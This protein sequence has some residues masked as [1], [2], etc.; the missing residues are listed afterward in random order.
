MSIDVKIVGILFSFSVFHKFLMKEKGQISVCYNNSKSYSIIIASSTMPNILTFIS[1][2]KKNLYNLFWKLGEVP[3]SLSTLN[4][5]FEFVMLT[6][7]QSQWHPEARWPPHPSEINWQIPPGSGR[8]TQEHGVLDLGCFSDGI[9]LLS[10]LDSDKA[11][12][13]RPAQS[14]IF[15]RHSSVEKISCTYIH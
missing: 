14:C 4:K 5:H 6:L 7:R 12:I 11:R 10:F 3:L 8:T 13:S 15:W 9:K 2:Q 1:K